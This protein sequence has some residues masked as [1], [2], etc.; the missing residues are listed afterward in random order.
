[1]TE[2]NKFS[3]HQSIKQ[4]SQHQDYHL[5]Y[6]EEEPKKKKR[7]IKTGNKSMINKEQISKLK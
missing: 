7:K 5:D 3:Q 4:F 6:N 2:D 1:M